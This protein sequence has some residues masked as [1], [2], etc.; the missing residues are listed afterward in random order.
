MVSPFS[1]KLSCSFSNETRFAGL[2]FEGIAPCCA[3]NFCT[4]G[5]EIPQLHGF[6]LTNCAA[7]SLHNWSLHNLQGVKVFSPTYAL[8]G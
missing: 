5:A 8:H 3:H 2:S 6:D 7:Q 1:K 4:Y